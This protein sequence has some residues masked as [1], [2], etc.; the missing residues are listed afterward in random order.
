MQVLKLAILGVFAFVVLRFAPLWYRTANF[1][2]YVQQQT[3]GIHSMGVLKQVILAKAEKNNLPITAKNINFTTADS[4]MQ[5][6]VEYQ[7]PLDLYFYQKELSFHASGK[8][9]NPEN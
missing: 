5:V 3:S 8:S 7:V 9:L 2:S 4:V 6:N 1:N